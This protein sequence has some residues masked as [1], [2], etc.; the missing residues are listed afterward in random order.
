MIDQAADKGHPLLEVARGYWHESRLPLTSLVFIAPLLIVYE[1]GILLLGPQAVR[2]GADVWLRQFLDLL[3]FGQYFLLPA[4][5]A[6]ILLAWHHTTG[7]RWR[8]SRAVLGG[9]T[10]ESAVLAIV[11]VLVA[12]L[13]G[14]LLHALAGPAEPAALYASVGSRVASFCGRLV[15]FI[16]AG[17]YEELLFRLMLLPAAMLG[18]RALGGSRRTALAGGIVA[19]SL[20]FSLAHYLGPQG[21]SFEAFGF[22]FRLVA[23][24]FF[25]GLFLVRGFGIAAGT[26]AGYDI[27]VGLIL[28]HGGS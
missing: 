20:V 3:G 4:L 28:G 11:L 26:H 24:G 2:N 10:A 15:G 23:G 18:I 21:E 7:Q 5:T 19:T 13:Q 12:M 8:C 17:I 6:S 27:L 25:A 14:L 1:G 9:M 22:L 16:G